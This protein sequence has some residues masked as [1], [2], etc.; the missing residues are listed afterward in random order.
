[1]TD[2]LREFLSQYQ[3]AAK[4]EYPHRSLFKSYSCNEQQLDRICEVRSAFSKLHDSL[5]DICPTIDRDSREY[6][7]VER[8]L[9]IACMYMV[10]II[11]K[12][13]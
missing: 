10:K 13:I 1:M 9:E 2:S 3:E 5:V 11:A 7:E 12:E 6:T 8:N 4:Q